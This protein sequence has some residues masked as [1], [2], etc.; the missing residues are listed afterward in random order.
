MGDRPE[1]TFLTPE[2]VNTAIDRE[3]PDVRCACIGISPTEATAELRPGAMVIRPGGY[4]SGPTLF[5]VADAALW[6]LAFGAGGRI[7]PLALTS[8]LSIRFLRP[9]QGDTVYARAELNRATRRT[10]IGTVTVWTDDNEDEPCATGQGTYV[11]P[12]DQ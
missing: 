5:A 4:I 7:E 9:A 1:P 10:V 11:L 3:W 2:D 6:Y 8:D 12:A